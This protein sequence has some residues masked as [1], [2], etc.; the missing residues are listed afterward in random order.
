MVDVITFYEE[1][2]KNSLEII[3][4]TP[5]S[6][7]GGFWQWV[8]IIISFIT[9]NIKCSMTRDQFFWNSHQNSI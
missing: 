1:Q 7:S 4:E 9:P 6:R 2:E 5:D 8:L 3:C